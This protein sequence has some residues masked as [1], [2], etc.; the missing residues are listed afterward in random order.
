MTNK[1]KKTTKTTNMGDSLA[2]SKTLKAIIKFK[3]LRLICPVGER[4]FNVLVV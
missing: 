4:R 2:V 1:K 3:L